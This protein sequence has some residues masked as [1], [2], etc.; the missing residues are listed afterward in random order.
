M[1]VPTP[2][3]SVAGILMAVQTVL[4]YLGTVAFAISGA[5]AAGR[6]HMDL[7]GVVVLG[8]IVAVG[9]GTLRD[10]LLNRTAFWVVDPN[11]LVAGAL[12]AALM[13]PI[14]RFRPVSWRRT[15]GLVQVFDAIGLALFVVTGINIALKSGA[16]LMAAAV[17]GIVSG[18]GGGVIRDVLADEIPSVL[19]GGRLYMTAALAGA[20]AYLG[21]LWLGVSPLLTIGPPILIVLGVRFASLRYDLRLPTVGLSDAGSSDE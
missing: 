20:L 12:T 7:G 15:Q 21:L 3:F 9:G 2:E 18:I 14:I 4:L 5:L 10:L 19:K 17:I 13:V 11:F 8:S 6:R 16:N 1:D